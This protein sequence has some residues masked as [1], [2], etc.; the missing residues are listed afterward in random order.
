MKEEVLRIENVTQIVDGITYLD[1]INFHIFKGEIMGL[2]PLNSQGKKEL[3]ELL[4]QNLPIQFGRIYLKDHLVNYYEHSNRSINRVYIIEQKTKLIEDL[5]VA[6]NIFVLR[7]GFKKY[8]IND[9]KLNKETHDLLSSLSIEINTDEYIANLTL[10][11]RC[12]VELVKAVTIGSPL[13]IINELSSFLSVVE[14][15]KFQMLIKHYCTEGYSFLYMVNHYE[16]AFRICSRIALMGDGRIV[17][18]FDQ[19]DFTDENMSHYIISFDLPYSN[20]G[21]NNES[22]LLE[23]KR[24]QSDV[25]RDMTFS[26]KAGECVAIL[27]MTN[28]AIIDIIELISGKKTPCEGMIFLKDKVLTHKMSSD[29]LKQGIAFIPENPTKSMLFK[30]LT[31]FENLIFLVDRKMNCSILKKGVL[32]NIKREY[33]KIVGEEIE[34]YN[35]KEVGTNS[36]YNLV[37]YQ[38][39]LYSPKIV[40]CIQP[41]SNADMYLRGHIITLMNELKKKGIA[42][43]I[44]AVSIGDSLSVA[45]R[46]L[47]IKNGQLIREYASSDFH[48]FEK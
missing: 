1:N 20:P 11:E 10:F 15:R 44:L 27:D 45:D 22:G 43:V 17:R 42:I 39:H 32:K 6:D 25:L 48:L 4:T 34:C 19:K 29:Y 37:Y 13:I 33:K 23:F 5:S 21:S 40:F 18:I 36:L 14:L 26:V 7:R 2:I 41:F 16:E 38:I 8:I 9:R 31:Y 30:D 47:T 3:I 24:I 12:V 46:L 35:L 28:T